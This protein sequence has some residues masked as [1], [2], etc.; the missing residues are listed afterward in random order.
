MISNAKGSPESA[1]PV[2]A[3]KA[4]DLMERLGELEKIVRQLGEGS[5]SGSPRRL[6]GA[7]SRSVRIGALTLLVGLFGAS[8]VFAEGEFRGVF[9]DKAGNVGIGTTEPG[10]YRLR[11][12]GSLSV[13]GPVKIGAD[14]APV[15]SEALRLVRGAVASNSVFVNQPKPGPGYEVVRV[16]PGGNIGSCPPTNVY[17]EISFQRPFTGMPVAFAAITSANGLPP[18]SQ[19]AVVQSLTEKNMLIK[20]TDA[21][22]SGCTSPA[23]WFFVVGST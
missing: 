18:Q 17:Y 21:N 13:S 22:T 12:N 7:Y 20:V 6:W 9:I 1:A 5:Q 19:S 8:M 16:L 2:G 14:V 3:N 4:Q 23:F 10:D 15:A 11:V